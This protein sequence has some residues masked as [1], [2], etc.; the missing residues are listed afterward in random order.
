MYSGGTSRSNA[1]RLDLLTG[2]VASTN[3]T[4]STSVAIESAK[5]HDSLSMSKAPSIMTMI[6]P[7][8]LTNMRS[9]DNSR[10]A[11]W[12]SRSSDD[13]ARVSSVSSMSKKSTSLRTPAMSAAP[14]IR[15]SFDS[16]YPLRMSAG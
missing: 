7:T 5:P 6:G 4:D 1:P 2:R 12:A 3:N 8:C 14:G 13:M 16:K 9:S 10:R 15:R 11:Q